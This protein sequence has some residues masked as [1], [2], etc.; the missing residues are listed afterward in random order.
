MGDPSFPKSISGGIP[1]SY[2]AEIMAAILDYKLADLRFAV[3]VGLKHAC[4][5]SHRHQHGGLGPAL[6]GQQQEQLHPS[7]LELEPCAKQLQ[8]G[9]HVHVPNAAVSGSSTCHEAP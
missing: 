1:E 8:Y 3:S 2:G 9:S 6:L 5:R 4:S 7:W